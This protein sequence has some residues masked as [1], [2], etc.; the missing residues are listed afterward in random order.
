M[1]R[2]GFGLAAIASFSFLGW[3]VWLEANTP[4]LSFGAALIAM[5]LLLSAIGLFQVNSQGISAQGKVV[6]WIAISVALLGVGF[7]AYTF[8]PHFFA[9][10]LWFLCCIPMG[11]AMLV[12]PTADINASHTD[13]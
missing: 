11:I 4:G 2:V 10:C 9:A 8:G 12:T 3:F 1:S 7:I 5:P 13:E 6:G